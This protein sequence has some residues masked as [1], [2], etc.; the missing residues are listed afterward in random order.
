MVKW[1]HRD[2]KFTHVLEFH[3][4]RFN[5]LSSLLDASCVTSDVTSDE[6]LHLSGLQIS[7]L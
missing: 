1:Q 6:L 2:M 3:R 4:P 7:Y 5:R